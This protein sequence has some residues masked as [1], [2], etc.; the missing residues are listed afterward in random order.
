MLA[1]FA[2]NRPWLGMGFHMFIPWNPSK[3]DWCLKHLPDP[4]CRLWRQ[5]NPWGE[6]VLLGTEPVMGSRGAGF[7]WL[8]SIGRKELGVPGIR[9]YLFVC[10]FAYL[11]IYLSIYLSTYLSIYLSIYLVIGR[12]MAS[13]CGF[14]G[15]LFLDKSLQFDVKKRFEDCLMLEVWTVKLYNC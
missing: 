3:T 8:V 12:G 14:G 1:T 11:S 9:I 2:I 5:C 15:T 4:V 7:S 6:T 10:L 13:H